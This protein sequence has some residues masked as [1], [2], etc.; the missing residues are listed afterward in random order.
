M[1]KEN[2]K[3]AVNKYCQL[4]AIGTIADVMPLCGEIE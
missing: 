1:G 4:V 2:L 3:Q